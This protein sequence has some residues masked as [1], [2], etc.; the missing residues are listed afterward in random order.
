M[1][2]ENYI[3]FSPE[4]NFT[5]FFSLIK[6]LRP[7]LDEMT[8]K[9]LYD[10]ARKADDYTLIGFEREGKLVA[11]M[12]YRVLHDLVHG[13]HLYIDDLVTTESVRSM[14]IGAILLKKAEAIAAELNCPNLRLCTGIANEG[15]KR[16]YEKNGWDFRSVVFKK[17]LK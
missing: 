16:F 8:F 14:G 6:E 5:S 7:H 9:N 4:R 12:G 10:E 11:A 2:A 15:G 17:K 1:T 3:T 13:R